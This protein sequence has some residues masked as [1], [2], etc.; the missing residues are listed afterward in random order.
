MP[1]G[2]LFAELVVTDPKYFNIEYAPRVMPVLEQYGA[3]FLVTGGNPE[4]RE[5][6]RDVSRV[7]LLE[8][9]SVDRARAFYDSKD[10]QDVIGYR[11]KAARAHLYILDGSNDC[12]AAIP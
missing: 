2:Y 3:K 10:Y 4:V 5:G 1:K 11:F 9:E 12:S 6:D 7:V 8:F